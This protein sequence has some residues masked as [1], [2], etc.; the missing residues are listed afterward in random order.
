MAARE[1]TGIVLRIAADRASEFEAMFE[2]EEIPIWDDFTARGRFAEA[3][4]IKVTGGSQTEAGIQDYLL[5]VVAVGD[6][7]AEHDRDP[8]FR[9][10]LDKAQKLQPKE[11]LVW[12]GEAVFERHAAEG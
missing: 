10:F 5:Q 4:L 12:F 8:R 1:I 9:A 7:H 6:A 2:A 3:R 11:P